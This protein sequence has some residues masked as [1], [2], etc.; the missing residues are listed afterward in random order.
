[1]NFSGFGVWPLPDGWPV[2]GV[3]AI[4][5]ATAPNVKPLANA[6]PLFRNPL[7]SDFMGLS[8][9]DEPTRKP[10]PPLESI[11]ERPQLQSFYLSGLHS[12]DVGRHFMEGADAT[13]SSGSLSISANVV[14]SGS[15]PRILQGVQHVGRECDCVL[16]LRAVH[17][18][19]STRRVISRKPCGARGLACSCAWRFESKGVRA[20]RVCAAARHNAR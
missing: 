15:H 13:M 5:G 3:W 14:C 11:G 4:P 1:M 19:C 2:P 17:D 9:A 7:R 20:E 6:A 8:F 18:P 16:F 10:L 12:A